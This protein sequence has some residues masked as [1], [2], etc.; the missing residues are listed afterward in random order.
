MMV[1]APGES[2]IASAPGYTGTPEIQEAGRL[3]TITVRV[4]EENGWT[5]YPVS[6]MIQIASSSLTWTTVLDSK[7]NLVSG[8]MEFYVRFMKPGFIYSITATDLEGTYAPA[9]SNPIPVT[10]TGFGNTAIADYL[11]YGVN[12]AVRG[13]GNIHIMDV[14]VTNPNSGG[15]Q[16]VFTG[17]TL[18][19]GAA[20]NSVVGNVVITDAA[21][22]TLSV[23]AWGSSNTVFAPVNLSITPLQQVSIRV[24]YDILASAPSGAFNSSIASQGDIYLQ[25]LDGTL[26]Y[27]EPAGAA[28]PYAAEQI[29][30][31]ET[32]TNIGFYNYPNPF[33]AGSGTTTIQYYLNRDS[34]V[35][36]KIFD[37]ISR[38]VK[39]IVDD[40]QQA[41]GTLHKYT[42]DGK[43]DDGKTVVN[44]V[45]YSVIKINGS[46]QH[47]TKIVVVK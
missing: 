33:A 6:N 32:N 7:K 16:Y 8:D 26:V 41:G 35:S 23:T 42:W 24:Y 1:L 9:F 36:L 11:K 29:N 19:A 25:K 12:T 46:E 2:F 30:I 18:T 13:Q 43:N 4:V 14:S 10:A 20:S 27:S 45:Y 39:V 21:G 44:G 38:K 31:I 34:K 28:F 22:G 15:A 5:T 47:Y 3:I 17:I 40:E 37:L